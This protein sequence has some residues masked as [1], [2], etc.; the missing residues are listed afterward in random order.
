MLARSLAVLP[1][2]AR[3]GAARAFSAEAGG[4][5]LNLSSEQKQMQVR[6]SSGNFLRYCSW[7]PFESCNSRRKTTSCIELLLASL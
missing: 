1:R 3:A 5:S 4:F 2:V 6:V 7:E